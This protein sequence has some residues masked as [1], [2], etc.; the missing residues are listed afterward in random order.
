VE[1]LIRQIH[2]CQRVL[3][4]LLTAKE[5]LRALP[6]TDLERLAQDLENAMTSG[7]R[8]NPERPNAGAEAQG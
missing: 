5:Q 6:L 7:H 1:G 2:L 4:Q 8:R 3:Q